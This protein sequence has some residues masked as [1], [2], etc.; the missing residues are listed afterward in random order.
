VIICESSHIRKPAISCI[1]FIELCLNIKAPSNSNECGASQYSVC[2]QKFF[3]CRN[4]CGKYLD[5]CLKHRT[6]QYATPRTINETSGVPD[7]FRSNPA[8][9]RLSL[10]L[11]GY[12]E[13][14][15]DKVGTVHTQS[16][17]S[18]NVHTPI[19]TIIVHLTKMLQ[20]PPNTERPA[21]DMKI[22]RCYIQGTHPDVSMGKSDRA[23]YG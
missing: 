11:H 21:Q 16:A 23:P 17:Q 14:E 22:E 20:D 5:E 19:I 18:L 6:R 7:N 15:I 9:L 13:E 10:H 3:T 4:I 1:C 12:H 2:N 8:S